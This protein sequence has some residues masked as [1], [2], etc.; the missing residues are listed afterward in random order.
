M[1]NF[2][3][4]IQEEQHMCKVISITNQK[5]GVGKTTTTVNLGIG[6]A[7]EGKKVLLIDADPQGS[8]TAS[9]GYVEP[10]EL[11]VTLA[12][13]MTKV[14]NE[15]EISEEDGILHHQENVDLLPANIELSTLE[16]TMGN[17]MSREMIM[18]EYIDTIRSRYDYI[19]IDCL[20][21]LGMMTINALVSSDSVLIPV[22]AAYLPVKGLQ[23]LIKTISMVKK[24][25][26]R[27]L[28]IE[29]ILLTMVDFRT[30]Y[31]KDIAALV[32]ETYGSQIAIFKNV[33][34]MSVK[35]AET[36][37]EGISIY[38]HCPK[39]K[40]SMAYMNLTQEVMSDEK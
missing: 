25:L 24:R 13:I 39:G 20:P 22:Q 26:N 3:E 33:I 34:P 37:A 18:K 29:G 9:L 32:Q 7:R 30:N 2:E 35:A 31:A 11:G 27:R 19:L 17:V 23:Q 38:T 10:D 5:G 8:L 16:V 4:R 14:I 12:T 15:D 6:M 36:S 21:S 1:K 40:V 28:T